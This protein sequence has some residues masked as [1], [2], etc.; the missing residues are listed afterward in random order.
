MVHPVIV[1]NRSRIKVGSI[2]VG[3]RAHTWNR[4]ISSE[5]CRK[6]EINSSVLFLTYA[7]LSEQELQEIDQQVRE[8]IDFE[9]IVFQ[10]ASPAILTN[11]GPGS[12]GLLYM[13]Q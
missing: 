3:T 1:L 4:Y 7:G 10:K 6:R 9:T 5:F 11:C 8:K 12:F 13:K 2:C